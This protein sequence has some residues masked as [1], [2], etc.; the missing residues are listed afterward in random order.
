MEGALAVR[1]TTIYRYSNSGR[2][3]GVL[4]YDDA[5]H[6]ED[7]D[8]TDKL[9]VT[10]T[11]F[12][13][14]G[15]RLVWKDETGRWHEHIVDGIRGSHRG[16]SQRNQ[17]TC[18][19]SVS[20]LFGIEAGG[21]VMKGTVKSILSRLLGLTRWEAGKC[22]GFGKVELE[23]WN[24]NVRECVADLCEECG[25]EMYTVTP[26]D[27]GGVKRRQVCI[28][29]RRGSA[30][31][32]RQFR[33]GRNVLGVDRE[34]A[35]DEVYTA[36]RGY[37][38][39]LNKKST[40]EYADRLQV[41]VYS[42]ANLEL[43]GTP[44][45]D[46]MGHTWAKYTDDAC[47][48]AGF[49][50]RQCKRQLRSL[51][52]PLVRYKFEAVEA[53]GVW[54]DVE[55]GNVVSCVDDEFDPPIEMMERVSGITRHLKGRNTCV[56]AIGERAKPLVEKFKA[57][58]KQTKRASGNSTRSSASAGVRTGGGSTYSGSGDGWTHQID[59]TNIGSGTVNFVT[60]KTD[61]KSDAKPDDWG[62]SGDSGSSTH[63]TST[64]DIAG[65]QDS[66]GTGGG[67][68]LSGGGGAGWG[69]TGGGG[70]F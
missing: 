70:A 67:G 59:G 42:S 26:V 57:Q 24:K 69:G 61:D 60:Y 17:L 40:S 20:E 28:V 8:G 53:D 6:E 51:S 56:V 49:L 16:S 5:V 41:A 7:L 55:L 65:S 63:H 15:E 32:T 27:E 35:T 54:S 9:T 44:T 52:K 62:G 22:S 66:S 25:G 1:D 11:E 18:S 23:V 45:S 2:S 43:W 39:K 14:K 33:Y 68:G 46:G 58:E 29:K 34:V 13:S 50:R 47:T 10:A 37:G 31:V 48:D 4:R 30:R 12:V 19:N 36:I 64:S 38:A 3:L 21:T